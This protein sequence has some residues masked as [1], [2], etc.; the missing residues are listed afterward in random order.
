MT[1][2][3]IY[4]IYKYLN[5]SMLWV[6]VEGILLIN[7]IIKIFEGHSGEQ[8]KVSGFCKIVFY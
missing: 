7:G 5:K 4:M 6:H 3:N 1:I 2:V 8:W